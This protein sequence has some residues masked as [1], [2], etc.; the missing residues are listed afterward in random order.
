MNGMTAEAIAR[1][2]RALKHCTK[3]LDKIDRNGSAKI[4]LNCTGVEFNVVK[5]DAI[6]LRIKTTQAQLTE[7]ILSYDIIKR[8]APAIRALSNAAEKVSAAAAVVAPAIKA[9]VPKRTKLSREEAIARHREYCRN[10]AA[11]K[12]A[13]AKAAKMSL[14]PSPTSA[15]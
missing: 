3:L 15:E 12:R 4:V 5:G 14:V 6:Y 11:R 13:E 7:D 8:E 9:E 2:S 1:K 10:Y